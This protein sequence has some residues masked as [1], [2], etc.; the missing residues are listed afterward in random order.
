MASEFVNPEVRAEVQAEIRPRRF[1]WLD[2]VWLVFLVGL[3][4]LPPRLEWHKQVF[5]LAIGIVQ[6]FEGHLIRRLPERG[7]VYVV[8]LKILLATTLIFHTGEV[9]INSSYYPIYYLPVVTA[10]LY[11]GPWMTLA[12]TAIA[13][14]AY[15]S[16]LYPALQEYEI[17]DTGLAQLGLRVVFFFLA[18]MLINRFAQESRRQTRLYQDLAEELSETNRRLRVAQ[19]EA[20]R[21]ERL[22]ALGQLSAGL[23][24]EIR[25]PLGVIKGSAEMLAQKVESSNDIAREMADYILTEVNRLSALVTQFLNFARPLHAELHPADLT[26]LLDRVLKKV[27]DQW[28]G[29]PVQVERAYATALPLVPLDESLCEQAFINL[30]QNAHEAMEERGGIL[31]VE[32]ARASQNGKKGV[33][34]RITDDGPGIP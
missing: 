5:L 19:A 32:V 14:A 15:C 1:D 6:L 4:L 20:R 12:W 30:V 9:A 16:Y 11:F 2:A 22:A 27:G 25:N 31:R 7:A 33:V 29:K 26:G 3:A 10:A 24:H 28:K 34:V 13:S 17:S 18:A 8:V 23:A 21:S